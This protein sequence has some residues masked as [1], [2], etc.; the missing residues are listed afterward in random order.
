M[1]TSNEH[2]KEKDYVGQTLKKLNVW[3]KKG[4]ESTKFRRLE[5]TK[6][7]KNI[8]DMIM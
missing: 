3:R 5:K 1:E 8:G 6:Q 2:L 4:F 7:D